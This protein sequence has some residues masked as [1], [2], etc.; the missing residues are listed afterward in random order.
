M[1]REAEGGDIWGSEIVATVLKVRARARGA[2]MRARRAKRAAQ[3]G[4]AA[5]RMRPRRAPAVAA[6]GL[7]ARSLLN[8]AS[9]PTLAK[10]SPPPF[11]PRPQVGLVAAFVTAAVLLLDAAQPIV[12]TT[13]ERFPGYS[14]Q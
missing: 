12:E 11:P 3:S 14:Q 8:I 5:T 10:P 1:K 4:T 2:R 13:V 7:P 9:L 6:G